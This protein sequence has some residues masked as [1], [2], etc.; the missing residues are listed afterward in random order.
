MIGEWL[1]Y[2]I[3]C[4]SSPIWRGEKIRLGSTAADKLKRAVEINETND[5]EAGGEWSIQASN[6]SEFNNFNVKHKF[7]YIN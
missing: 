4:E 1:G 5:K 2:C 7:M 3:I 6:S